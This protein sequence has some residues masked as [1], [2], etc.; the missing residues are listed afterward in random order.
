MAKYLYRL[1]QWSIR[2]AKAV[3]FATVA[4]LLVMGGLV[5][6][7]GFEFDEDLSIPGTSSQDTL[8]L[9]KKEFPEVGNAGG[10]IHIVF[11]A[12]EGKTLLDSEQVQRLFLS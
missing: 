12:P 10:Q 4:L 5:L 7:F 9:L 3:I 8:E 1:G 6:G 11:K 2:H